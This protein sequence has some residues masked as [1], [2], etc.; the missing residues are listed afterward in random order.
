MSER[1]IKLR[2][3]R[4]NRSYTIDGQ[5][6]GN[7]KEGFDMVKRLKTDKTL[8]FMDQARCGKTADLVFQF[9]E[10]VR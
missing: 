7:V 8:E 1:L 3:S 4:I 9:K 10:I 2:I 5:R 6:S